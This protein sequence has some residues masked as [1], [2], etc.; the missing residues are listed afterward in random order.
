MSTTVCERFL[1]RPRIVQMTSRFPGAPTRKDRLRITQ[2]TAVPP[3]NS[4]GA[5][6]PAEDTWLEKFMLTEYLLTA[7][8]AWEEEKKWSAAQAG[9]HFPK[10][11]DC[12]VK[13]FPQ[14]DSCMH[15]HLPSHDHEPELFLFNKTTMWKAALKYVALCWSCFHLF[16][17][18]EIFYNDIL[19]WIVMLLHFI[20]TAT[21]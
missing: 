13:L 11:K 9:L 3:S 17:Y 8:S 15:L 10:Q 2:A 1:M 20:N 18:T 16:L 21:I 6:C 4:S 12:E 5:I 7:A 14:Y 19:L